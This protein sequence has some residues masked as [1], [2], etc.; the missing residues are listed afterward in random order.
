[1]NSDRTSYQ[2][3][4]SWEKVRRLFPEGE[5]FRVL[6]LGCGD[7][8]LVQH[9][10]AKHEVYGI[11]SDGAAVRRAA[12]NG[13]KAIFGSLEDP[14]PFSSAS[15]DVVL[16]LDVIEHVQNLEQLLN[17]A[18]RVCTPDGYIILSTP[19]HFD[20]RTRLDMLRGKGIIRWSQRQWEKA[21]WSY[22]HI[23]FLTLGELR[24]LLELTCWTIDREQYNFMSGGLLPTR[25]IPGFKRRFLIRHWPTLW[26]GKFVIRA[27]LM[28]D[29][30]TEKMY[31]DKTPK[32]F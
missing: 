1:M 12:E 26:S 2:Y 5:R 31:I 30:A 16:A 18:R 20:L 17:E 22:S 21:A 23:R 7:G 24:R 14:L 11:D 27:R 15:F 28:A 19:N 4:T 6:D 32:D 25:W 8:R 10:V 3:N 9:L 13:V 29:V